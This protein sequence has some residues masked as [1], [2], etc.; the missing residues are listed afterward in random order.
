MCIIMY[1][2]SGS[3]GFRDK[4]LMILVASHLTDYR[5]KAAQKFLWQILSF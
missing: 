5:E 1:L 2:D 3:T 4:S